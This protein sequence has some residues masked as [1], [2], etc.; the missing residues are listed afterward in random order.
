MRAGRFLVTLAL[1]LLWS[2]V[3]H[4]QRV[5]L[6][7]VGVAGTGLLAPFVAVPVKFVIL[8]PLAAEATASRLW[9]IGAIEW[10]LWF[11]VTAIAVLSGGPFAAP[12]I[13]PLLLVMAV[14]VHTALVEKARWGSA[15]ILSLA[16]PILAV[17]IPSLAF[18][19][20]PLIEDFLPAWLL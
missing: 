18:V 6:I 7:L 10:L 8:R 3:A 15:L 9:L 11:P 2:N 19:S 14:W 4:A 13:A 1:I 17:A 16:T 12:L 5:P 20:V